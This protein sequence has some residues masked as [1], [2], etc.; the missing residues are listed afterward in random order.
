MRNQDLFRA[1]EFSWNCGTL[2]N[3]YLQH[4]KE[5][6]AGKK[7]PDFLPGYFE[8]F[9]FKL[10]ILFIDDHKQGIFSPN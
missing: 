4:E 7:S 1:G 8:K 5:R 9:H 10:E 6:P 3:V 2:I